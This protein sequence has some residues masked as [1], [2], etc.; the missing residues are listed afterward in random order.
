MIKKSNSHTIIELKHC[1]KTKV[2]TALL[3]FVMIPYSL[4][5]SHPQAVGLRK[6]YSTK[7]VF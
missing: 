5:I 3:T 4:H 1:M 2:S 7:L 6:K